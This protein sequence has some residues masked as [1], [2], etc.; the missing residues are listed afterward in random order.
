M[1]C[2]ECGKGMYLDDTERNF[3]GNYDRYWVS[4]LIKKG[5]FYET[6]D[7]DDYCSYSERKGF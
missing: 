1:I 4:T 3:P 5:C 2:K 7:E 6:P